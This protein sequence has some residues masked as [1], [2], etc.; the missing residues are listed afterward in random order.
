M[1]QHFD[2]YVVSFLAGEVE[3]L[4]MK[5]PQDAIEPIES[6]MDDLVKLIKDDN[7][8]KRSLTWIEVFRHLLFR[9]DTTK[10][11]LS[12]FIDGNERLLISHA[13]VLNVLRSE[14][15]QLAENQ[16]RKLWRHWDSTFTVAVKSKGEFSLTEVL[17]NNK[18]LEIS[19]ISAINMDTVSGGHGK[20]ISLTSAAGM[21]TVRAEDWWDRPWDEVK[22]LS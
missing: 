19:L 15:K 12:V 8:R 1:L 18:G 10:K 5:C 3:F 20:T 16:D 22:L 11:E 13:A 7:A 9:Y 6:A 17:K 14:L 2:C 21:T 4:T